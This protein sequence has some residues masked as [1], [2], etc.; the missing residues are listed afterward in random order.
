MSARASWRGL[1]QSRVYVMA[2]LCL[3]GGGDD[4]DGDVCTVLLFHVRGR[5]NHDGASGGGGCDGVITV[6][7]AS[8]IAQ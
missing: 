2:V 6:P 4:S 5:A 3:N 8:P 1:P 7:Q